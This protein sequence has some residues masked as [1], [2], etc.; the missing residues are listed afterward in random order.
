MWV[1]DD[2]D[3]AARILD[4]LVHICDLSLCEVLRVEF[5]VFIALKIVILLSPL[6]IAPEHIN[7]EAVHGKVSITFYKHLSRYRIPLAEM[8]AKRVDK[9]HGSEAGHQS[10]V[11]A[12]KLHTIRWRSCSHSVLNALVILRVTLAVIL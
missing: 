9:R 8:I 6:D 11:L 1:D 3:T 10:Q 7:G 2:D 5:E 4:R 12:Q